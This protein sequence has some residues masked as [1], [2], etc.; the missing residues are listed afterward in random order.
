MWL[1]QYIMPISEY[2]NNLTAAKWKG[3]FVPALRK[4]RCG[5]EELSCIPV[6]GKNGQIPIDR[7]LSLT[8]AQIRSRKCRQRGLNSSLIRRFWQRRCGCTWSLIAFANLANR[9][10]V[11]RSVTTNLLGFQIRFLGPIA[12]SPVTESSRRSAGVHRI[13]DR[14]APESPVC[15]PAAFSGGCR[16]TGYKHIPSSYR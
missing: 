12:G 7:S 1:L 15:V 6:S 4:V 3:L 8:C 13:F 16:R 11:I 5:T 9:R 2:E 14:P 10:G